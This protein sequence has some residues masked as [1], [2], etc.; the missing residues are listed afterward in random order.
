MAWPLLDTLEH[1]SVEHQDTQQEEQQDEDWSVHT[2]LT[3]LS[4]MI[5][6]AMMAL[7]VLIMVQ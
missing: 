4:D 6:R 5:H 3:S 1:E 2:G 7:M